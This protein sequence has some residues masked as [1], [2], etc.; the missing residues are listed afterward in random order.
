MSAGPSIFRRPLGSLRYRL[1]ALVL[2]P[3]LLLAITVV[4]FA[5][6]WT[7]NYTYE[8]LFTKVNTDLRVA[9]DSFERIQSD[10]QRN[11][12]SFAQSNIVTGL[13]NNPSIVNEW[14]A[15]QRGRHN[16]DY[17]MLL[18]ADGTGR[19]D[20]EGW[21]PHTLSESPLTEMALANLSRTQGGTGIEIVPADVWQR[22]GLLQSSQVLFP[23][24]DTPRAA[25][26]ER[27]EEDRAMVI[28]CTSG[29]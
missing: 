7:S 2:I 27:S 21:K 23:L 15:Q 20:N 13:L 5:A 19:L 12:R 1:L 28:R 6:R 8:Q 16:L 25:P 17:L 4:L 11:F 29:S 18:N 14:L 3:L 22:D 26:T 24:I 10:Q 9:H